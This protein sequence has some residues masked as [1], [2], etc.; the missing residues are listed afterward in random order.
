MDNYRCLPVL[1][2]IL[3]SFLLVW[4]GRRDLFRILFITSTVLVILAVI[5]DRLGSNL[6]L[7][8]LFLIPYLVAFTVF[9]IN[10]HRFVIIG[11]ESIPK[12]GLLK[13]TS[14]EFRFAGWLLF[15]GMIYIVSL[16]LVFLIYGATMSIVAMVVK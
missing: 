7:Y 4:E 2:I 5:N 11:S 10:C 13:W 16:P 14:R 6:I 1:N 12:N 8:Y 9:S 15:L 3:G